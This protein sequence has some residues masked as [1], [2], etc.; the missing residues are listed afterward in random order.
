MS[1]I[2]RNVM[3]VQD[4][5]AQGD[6]G[7]AW[8]EVIAAAAGMDHVRFTPDRDKVD[9]EV[10]LLEEVQGTYH[11]A[12]KVQVKTELGLL[13]GDDGIVRYR[14]DIGTYDFLR[15]TNHGTPRV[16]VVFGLDQTGERVTLASEGTVLRGYG[17]WVSLAGKPGVDAK[18]VVV[19]LPVT[20]RMDTAGLRDMVIGYGV[21]QSTVVPAVEAWS[22][23]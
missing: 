12:V 10:T 23:T 22:D 2:A 1:R 11:P 7:E 3:G 4:N 14:L 8:V 21:R 9:V 18:S 19:E 13:P 6:F 15:R 16:L 17:H 20:N 5:T